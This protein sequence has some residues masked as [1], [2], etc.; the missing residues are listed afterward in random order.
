[1]ELV[2]VVTSSLSLGEL[3]PHDAQEKLSTRLAELVQECAR[4]RGEVLRVTED[5]EHREGEASAARQTVARLVN[6]LDD[7]KRTVQEQN[8]ALVEYR[9]EGDDLRT[10]L[11]AL[12]EEVKSVRERLHN[13]NK[14]YNATLEELHATEKHLQHT[15]G[16]LHV[17]F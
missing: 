8:L 10:R 9:K 17:G 4:L 14:S 12:E 13:T 6:E 11:R 2:R 3:D 1:M 5:L 16:K 15:K 7:E